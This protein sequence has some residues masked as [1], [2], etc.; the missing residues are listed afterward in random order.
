MESTTHPLADVYTRMRR[1]ARKSLVL[2]G[3]CRGLLL[4]AGATSGEPSDEIKIRVEA[5]ASEINELYS[6]IQQVDVDGEDV[7]IQHGDLVES[8]DRYFSS[9]L[10]R[11]LAAA[12][13]L[14]RLLRTIE[15][16]IYPELSKHIREAKATLNPSYTMDGEMLKLAE[17]AHENWKAGKTK[18]FL[19]GGKLHDDDCAPTWILTKD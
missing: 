4:H 5:I 1:I 13:S 14:R 7:L 18:Q 16:P 2:Q 11:W 6:A 19:P 3:E 17:Q 9:M 12:K 10:K 8:H 15:H